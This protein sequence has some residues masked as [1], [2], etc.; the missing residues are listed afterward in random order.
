MGSTLK[1]IIV[2]LSV[3]YSSSGAT[4]FLEQA[5]ERKNR[6]P[7]FQKIFINHYLKKAQVNYQESIEIL[8]EN[9]LREH[10]ELST[11]GRVLYTYL[12]SPQT[13]KDER[14]IASKTLHG[15]FHALTRLEF[16]RMRD[17]ISFYYDSSSFDERIYAVTLRFASRYRALVSNLAANQMSVDDFRFEES[18]LLEGI[19]SLEL[20]PSTQE[21][22]QDLL[23]IEFQVR[24]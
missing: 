15:D 11:F 7:L 23:F 1:I 3:F 5:L 21:I 22:I 6:S 24:G 9:E 17:R 8:S 2:F 19:Y 18:R 13:N 14:K 12:S 16:S 10:L 4:S 20:E